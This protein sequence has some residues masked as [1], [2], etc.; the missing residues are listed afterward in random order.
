LEGGRV[1][2]SMG[3]YLG[4]VINERMDLGRGFLNHIKAMARQ[5]G[6]I[7]FRGGFLIPQH[8]GYF[9]LEKN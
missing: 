2:E 3:S 8:N 5:P 4:E 1:L 9:L 6:K 7:L